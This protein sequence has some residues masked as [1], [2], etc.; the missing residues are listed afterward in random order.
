MKKLISLSNNKYRSLNL[1]NIYYASLE[2][3][4]EL[5]KKK[6]KKKIVMSVFAHRTDRLVIFKIQMTE[7]TTY[8][9]C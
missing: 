7:A 1:Q 5:A 6:E 8:V 4:H 2:N 9:E 3:N